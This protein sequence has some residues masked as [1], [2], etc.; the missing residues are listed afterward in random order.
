[1]VT[2]AK[3]PAIYPVVI[4][5]DV[6]NLRTYNFYIVENDGQLILVDAGYNDETSWQKLQDVLKKNGFTL[7]DLD[8]ILLTHHHFDHIGLVN[9]IIE[10][11]PIPV[12]AH[13]QAIVR[14]K[15]DPHYLESRIRFFNDLYVKMGCNVDRVAQEIERLR[16][17]VE[18]NELQ[19]VNSEIE[20]LQSGDR[21]FG[22]D[23]IEVIGHSLDHIAFYHKESEQIL[24]GDHMIQHMSSNALI[25]IDSNG[26]RPKSLVYYEKSLKKL[27]DLPIKIAYPGHGKMITEPYKLL[28]EKLGRI[29]NRGDLILQMLHKRQTAAEIAQAVYKDRYDTLFPLVMSE[30]IGH[31]DR[32]VYYGRIK[33]VEVEGVNYYER[34]KRPRI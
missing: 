4:E 32:L 18:K 25:D 23:V 24:V 6:A 27:L 10:K 9:R 2:T 12:Y 7:H 5:T 19:I 13:E 22:F 8:A 21:V 31:I 1:M 3:S 29:K 16:I 11:H 14:L 28:H 26:Q 20:I 34:S 30:V 33:K 17:Y 15:R